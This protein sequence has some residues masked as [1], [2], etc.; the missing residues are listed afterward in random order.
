MVA[1]E[2]SKATIARLVNEFEDRNW[3]VRDGHEYELTDSGEFVAEE[4]L[5]LVDRM[6][7]EITLRD[8]WQWFPTDLPGCTMS[9]FADA[10]IE[11]PEG[12]S[13]Y[14]PLSRVVEL[15]GS[16]RAVRAF[17]KRS[18]KP[19]SYEMFL[20][21]AIDGTEVEFLHPAAVVEDMLTVTLEELIREAVDSGRYTVLEHDS[22]PTDAGVALI[23]DRLG[24][25]CRDEKGVTQAGVDTDAPEAVAWGESLYEEVRSEARPVDLLGR[26]DG[27]TK[28]LLPSQF[29]HAGAIVAFRT[30]PPVLR[31]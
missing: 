2:A 14:H 31:H 3:V 11:L 10:T 5:R 22:L 26:L 16:A 6:G 21:N 30:S 13:P 8:V 18:L 20:R 28:R 1:T 19:G 7:T 23:D 27:E 4:F 9:M 17:S 12:Y 24:L 29:L 15:V 25:Y